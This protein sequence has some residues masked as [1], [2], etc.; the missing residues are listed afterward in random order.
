MKHA[1]VTFFRC[2]VFCSSGGNILS[3]QGSVQ[4]VKQARALLSSWTLVEFCGGNNLSVCARFRLVGGARLCA[5]V[6]VP[7]FVVSVMRAFLQEHGK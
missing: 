1:C 2:T 5:D 4:K 6:C 7:L 3:P